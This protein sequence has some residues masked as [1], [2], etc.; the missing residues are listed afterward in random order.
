MAASCLALSFSFLVSQDVTSLFE[1]VESAR[2]AGLARRGQSR[3][4]TFTDE[5]IWTVIHNLR[6]EDPADSVSPQELKLPEW[7]LFSKPDPAKNNRDL[8]LRV[9]PP[10]ARY[11]RW[12]EQVILVEKLREVRALVGFTRLEA[13]GDDSLSQLAPMR[14]TKPDWVPAAEVRGEGLFLQISGRCHRGM[15][16]EMW[17][18]RRAIHLGSSPVEAAKKSRTQC[19]LSR[20]AIRAIAF[21][22]ARPNPPVLAGVRIRVSQ[23]GRA[24]LRCAPRMR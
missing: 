16:E 20:P 5:Q 11:G 22:F 9:G 13:A 14:R 4:E 23:V 12:I 6:N 10:P 17:N 7:R 2:E 8:Q 21:P 1:G 24:D 3:Y 15:A 19:G 18:F